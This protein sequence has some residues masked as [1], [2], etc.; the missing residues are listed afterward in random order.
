MRIREANIRIRMRIRIRNTA[1]DDQVF[2]ASVAKWIGIRNQ[3]KNLNRK[4]D[5][6]RKKGVQKDMRKKE[7]TEKRR[8]RGEEKQER[9]EEGRGERGEGETYETC[10]K[11]YTLLFSVVIISK[12]SRLIS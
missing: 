12:K 7:E 4:H 8:K 1:S 11:E 5:T 6:M 10:E 9:W 3:K 2:V